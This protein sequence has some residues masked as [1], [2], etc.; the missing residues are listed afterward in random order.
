MSL[1]ITSTA[2]VVLPKDPFDYV[3]GQD[4]AIKI[5]RLCVKQRRHL[6]LIGPPG[7][8][9]TMIAQ[10]MAF[11][12][13]KPNDEISVLHNPSNPERPIL[14]V[15]KR[16]EIE[17]EKKLAES[18]G[19]VVLPS[20]VPPPVAERLGFR[21]RRCGSLSEP[22]ETFCSKCGADKRFTLSSPFEDLV[23]QQKRSS[24]DTQEQVHA[25]STNSDGT[26][27]MIVYER[28][29]NKILKLS[30]SDLQK[31][32]KLESKKLRNVI[33]PLDRKCF[34]YA[35]GASETELLG[36]VRH[37]PYGGHPEIGVPSYRR[38]I[39]GAIHEA[40]EGVLYIDELGTLGYLQKYLLSAMQDKRYPIVGK[41]S[42]STGA[43]VR[44]DGVPCDF[45]LVA[46][47]NVN[48]LSLLIPPL[49]S[50]FSGDGYEVVVNTVMVDSE[51]NREKMIKFIAQEIKK[52]RKIPHADMEA[53]N[54]ILEHARKMAMLY[55]EKPGLSLRLRKL[56]G[57][58]KMAG[59]IAI[60]EGSKLI[61]KEHVALALKS[62]KTAEE[63]LSELYGENWWNIGKSDYTVSRKS[64]GGTESR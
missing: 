30:Y 55:D 9:K 26:E 38:I 59:D 23:A 63:Q 17:K 5:A 8:G 25:V 6:L 44:V 47:I 14:E 28:R 36:D 20:R 4:Y 13:P 32:K 35:T 52:D 16:K 51:E 48:D 50:R 21:C 49:R 40:H 62:A 57:I 3:V 27:E 2:D 34:V 46:S 37:D 31:L 1:S 29:G 42:S 64:E 43:S 12:L 11:H 58:I 33:V 41:N 54:L 61:E 45:I 15:R 22:L 7:T 10:A 19:N 39:P 24:S 56:S 18:L 53:V 60:S